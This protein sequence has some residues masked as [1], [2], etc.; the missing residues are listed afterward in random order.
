[1]SLLIVNYEYPPIGAG[2]ANASFYL[3]QALTRRRQEVVV[4]S[5]EHTSE[6]QSR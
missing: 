6:L 3:A 4:R 5:E 2:A 1:M